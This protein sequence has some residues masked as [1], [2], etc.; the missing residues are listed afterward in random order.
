MSVRKTVVYH[1]SEII[2]LGGLK[3]IYLDDLADAAAGLFEDS[4]HALA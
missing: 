4:L 1:L 3:L 2:R